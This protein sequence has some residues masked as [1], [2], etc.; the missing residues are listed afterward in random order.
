ML[1][2]PPSRPYNRRQEPLRVLDSLEANATCSRMQDDRATRAQPRTFER[3][4]RCAPRHGQ[5]ARLLKG[6]TVRPASQK[7]RVRDGDAC[8]RR[9]REAKCIIRRIVHHTCRVA[10]WRAGVTR[11]LSEH[12]EHVAE[13][14]ADGT[15]V[16]QQLVSA[17]WREGR[18]RLHKQ[19]AEC[20][21]SVKLQPC[22]MAR[23]LW[24]ICEAWHSGRVRTQQNLRLRER[25]IVI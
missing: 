23:E 21:A 1:L 18:L 12:V 20:A 8:E 6:Q 25:R 14:E 13:V 17:D 10:A 7:L 19:A 11:V 15:D 22:I 4:V 5:C 2:R 9:I 3:H 24:R 16:Q